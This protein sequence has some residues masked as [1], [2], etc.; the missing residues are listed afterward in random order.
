[1]RKKPSNSFNECERDPY[2]M[3][4]QGMRKLPRMT[5]FLYRVIRACFRISR[6]CVEYGMTLWWRFRECTIESWEGEF[7]LELRDVFCF[8]I[9]SILPLL[10]TSPFL[11]NIF[12]SS[13]LY[14]SRISYHP[15]QRLSKCSHDPREAWLLRWVLAL[16]RLWLSHVHR[17]YS[18]DIPFQT[19][20]IS[21]HSPVE[22]D[23]PLFPPLSQ[24]VRDRKVSLWTVR[25]HVPDPTMRVV[26]SGEIRDLAHFHPRTTLKHARLL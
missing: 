18:P 8:F 16:L 24:S 13:S 2:G 22:M 15:E 14:S 3:T 6:F 19:I 20:L 25:T 12:P 9:W 5:W 23:T 21:W 4:K 1:M 17:V 7:S 11:W 26:A 10:E